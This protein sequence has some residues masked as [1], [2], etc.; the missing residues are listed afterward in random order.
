MTQAIV[1]Q[2]FN[3]GAT[4]DG[5]ASSLL[6]ENLIRLN[7]TAIDK[8]HAIRMVGYLLVDCDF[9]HPSYVDSMIAREAQAETSL[10]NGVAIPHGRP[11]ERAFIRRTGVA[12][13]QLPSGVDWG[14]GQITYLVFGIAAKT[15]EHLGILARL[16]DLLDNDS[17]VRSLRK[18]R[19]KRDIIEALAQKENALQTAV[20]PTVKSGGLSIDVTIQ[21]T[22]GLHA[23][24]ASRFADV[25]RKVSSH[26]SVQARGC[27]A[28]AKS[29]ASLLKLGAEHGAVLPI[30]SSGRDPVP[31]LEELRK[32]I[33][34]D[35]PG[36]E[37]EEPLVNPD[38]PIWIPPANLPAIKGVA[39]SPGI[40]IGRI[41]K[42][43][44]LEFR[45][46]DESSDPAGEKQ[47]LDIAI[48]AALAEL[49]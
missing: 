27:R 40:V 19:S 12:V 48:A 39:A 42:L 47:K 31:A 14:N 45:A 16:T 7:A 11:Q 13:L 49:N 33:L 41:H 35:F 4:M 22:A 29:V 34:V 5:T 24:P 1:S 6:E 30:E 25:A 38:A 2:S 46:K 15:D 44:S 32:T 21:T 23:L 3:L 20:E 26:I 37:H 10:G 28:D 17:L 8:E 18:T 9:V 36:M 43:S